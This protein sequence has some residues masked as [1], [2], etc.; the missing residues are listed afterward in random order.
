[1]NPAFASIEDAIAA[2]GQGKMV[3]V[4]DDEDRENEGDLT[5][6]AQHATP[7]SIAFMAK[8]GRGLICTAL[9]GELLD[10]LQIPQMV[11]DNS[12]PFETAFCVS[13][14]A[15]HGT[16]TGI[17][18]QDRA[19][20]IQALIAENARPSDFV[21]PG[22]TFPLRARPGGVLART[23]Q[24]EASVDL[25]RLAGLHP[26]GVICEIMKDDGTMAR[27]PDLLEFCAAHGLPMVTVA[28]LV[29]YRLQKDPIVQASATY[30]KETRWGQIAVH[31]FQN[32]LDSSCHLAFQIGDIGAHVP[33]VRVHL[34]ALPDDLDGFG[35]IEASSF[36]SSMSAIQK[37]GCGVLVYL[38]RQ[39]T[40]GEEPAPD[41]M[42]RDVG[43]GSQ[44]LGRLGITKMRLL[45]RHEKRYAALKG[46]GLDIVEQVALEG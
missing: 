6:A 25:A 16:S 43:I 19:K 35:S 39:A 22:H 41:Q 2:I 44:I 8:H 4:V 46:F 1:L 18:A 36:H 40:D 15:K 10:R 38:R 42:Q 17:S 12:S 32:I 11:Q 29:A 20:T 37:D 34:E 33:L 13:V 24:T 5:I 21:K 26:S 27:V 30:A 28:S 3:V 14:E 7:E 31:E 23:G 45:I 9:E